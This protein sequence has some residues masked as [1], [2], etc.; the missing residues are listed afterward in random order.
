[1]PREREPS[2]PRRERS[3]VEAR[4]SPILDEESGSVSGVMA[5]LRQTEC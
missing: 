4:T 1:M 2:D 3:R 5:L